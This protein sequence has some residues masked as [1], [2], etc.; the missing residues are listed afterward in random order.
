MRNAW[1]IEGRWSGAGCSPL[2]PQPVSTRFGAI[3]AAERRRSETDNR[4]MLDPRE[5]REEVVLGL[6]GAELIPGEDA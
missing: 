4:P 2:L 6:P 5:G 3:P 1:L